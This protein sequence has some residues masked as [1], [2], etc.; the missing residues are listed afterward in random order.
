MLALKN[1]PNAKDQVRPTQTVQLTQKTAEREW[2]RLKDVQ[3]LTGWSRQY[4]AKLQNNG[5]LD[6]RQDYRRA[7]RW[8]RRSQIVKIIRGANN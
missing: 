3:R 4:V 7:R 2:I 6:T 5:V 1:E 8:Y